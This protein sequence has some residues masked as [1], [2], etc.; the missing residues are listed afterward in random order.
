LGSIQKDRSSAVEETKMTTP[1]LDEYLQRSLDSLKD[2]QRAT[3]K[4]VYDNL[5]AKGQRRM[6]VADEVGLGKTVVARGVIAQRIADKIRSGDKTPLKVTYICSNQVIAHENVGK[7]DIYPNKKSHDQFASR[8]TY[9]SFEPDGGDKGLLR[10]NTL[11][12][13][14]SFEKGSSTGQ[15]NERRILYSLLMHDEQ[16]REQSKAV[17][18][19]LRAGVMMAASEWY[20]QL[21]GEREQ[22]CGFNL[23]RCCHSRF[24][25]AIRKKR[26]EYSDGQLFEQLG[27]TKDMSL[28][29]ATLE[30]T[31]F[32]TL[33]NFA[34]YREGCD[35]LVRALKDTLSEV[36]VDYIDAD[37]YIL[38]EFQRFKELVD[39]DC[40]SDAAEI[41]KKI[42]GKEKARILLL[43][44]T[45]FKAYTNDSS[46]ESGEEH[47]KEFSTILRFLFDGDQEAL[48]SYDNHRQALF[49]QLLEL[50]SQTETIDSTHR[51]A[52]QHVLRRVIC[53]TERLCV[54]DNFNAMTV[55][56]W[57]TTPLQLAAGDI[58]NFIATD[59]VVRFLN[60]TESRPIHQLH[61]PIEFCK[62]A[63]YPLSFLDDYKI[64]FQIRARKHEP[65]LRKKLKLHANAWID[66][67]FVNKY[68]LDFRGRSGDAT[69]A[70]FNQ[71]LQE[72]LGE[73]GEKLLWIPPSL[74][75]YPL[76]GEFADKTGFSKTLIF[77]AWLMVPRML[78]SLI[79]YEVERKTIGNTGSVESQET[80]ERKYFHS[81]TEK[82]HPIPQL[83]FS[84]KRS[85]A[86]ESSS[87]MTNFAL[88]YP[89]QTLANAFSPDE[90]LVSGL[91]L[92][93][94]R[95]T[96]TA[97]FSQLI[98]DSELHRFIEPT[99]ESDKWY[100]AAPLLL[101]RRTPSM[102][103]TVKGWLDKSPSKHGT[104]Y[105]DS[106]NAE[107]SSKRKH[108]AE[109]ANCFN[110]PSSTGLGPIPEDLPQWLADM[111]IASPAVVALRCAA[112]QFDSDNY[113]Q[114]GFAFDVANEFIS[115]FN[116]PESIAA[117]RMSTSRF[118]YWQRVLQYCVDGCLQSVMEEF[119]H[120]LKT[121]CPTLPEM[122]SR[123]V[124]SMN[125]GTASIKVDDLN[126]FLDDKRRNM[127]C[128]YAVDLGNQ[129]METDDG[130]KRIKG[131]RHNFNSPFRPFVLATTSI[132][133]EGLDFHTYC[134]KIVHWN[135]PSNPIDL[136]QREGRINRFK[137]LVIRQQIAS[138]YRDKLNHG[139]LKES[140][141]WEAL[142]KIADV[143]ERQGTGKC[144][145]IPYWH[146]KADSHLLESLVSS[147][148]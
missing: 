30:F 89:S 146:V 131:I 17:S 35:Q 83:V 124:A 107:G 67:R 123:I 113:E 20:K 57:Q 86:G 2:F 91:S 11:T 128:H 59:S 126:S 118:P 80:P 51:D 19:M 116:K 76:S 102:H 71:V 130:K 121:D 54:S 56:K 141:A 36:C 69:N 52:V 39:K 109:L 38:D 43:S 22:P 144:E 135:L 10:L 16:L 72:T 104:T 9:L 114:L 148:Q 48:L 68:K 53:R 105:F 62:S 134:R 3:V 37:I 60:K 111:S 99:G 145:L 129:R 24:L 1:I 74:P 33:K 88:I 18:A 63:P 21:E 103:N 13:A 115:M 140:N 61:P 65:E 120:V 64:K 7:L 136:E 87:N 94:I 108:F 66:H 139:L 79:S 55:D 5:F 125:L 138:K 26:I 110:D 49:K 29:K 147:L 90:A 23:R 44:A 28:Y 12:P 84:Q 95:Q 117:V 4:V 42:F 15:Q 132:G 92:A 142:F 93:E 101:D 119:F 73:N 45:P 106:G 133:Q 78:S 47:Y 31:Q 96:L 112:K 127:R 85:E 143:E 46:W 77:S 98:D 32:I 40:E 137:G 27:R 25:K 58:N 75:C 14:T 6:L 122:L 41:A 34:Q 100:W 81:K 70:K 97:K 50:Q 8:L 82:R